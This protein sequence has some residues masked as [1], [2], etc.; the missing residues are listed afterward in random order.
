[1]H[2]HAGKKLGGQGEVSGVVGGGRT[3]PLHAGGYP[4]WPGGVNRNSCPNFLRI[5]MSPQLSGAGR[6]PNVPEEKRKGI[7]VGP[8][9]LERPGPLSLTSSLI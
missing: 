5:P 1:M 4:R 6:Q 3:P 8:V 7:E 9:P 2:V